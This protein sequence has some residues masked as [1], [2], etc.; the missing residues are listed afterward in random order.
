MTDKWRELEK[1]VNIIVFLFALT[2]V[3]LS[4]AI[5]LMHHFGLMSCLEVEGL[6][7]AYA[8]VIFSITYVIALIFYWRKKRAKRTQ[9]G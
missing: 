7:L 9:N 4:W 2:L 3:C 5:V 1:I 6:G 8:W